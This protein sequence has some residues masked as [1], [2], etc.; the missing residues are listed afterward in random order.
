MHLSPSGLGIWQ[1]KWELEDLSFKYLDPDAYHQ[2]ARQLEGHRQEREAFVR[3]AMAELSTGSRRSRHRGGAVGS[4]QAHL[5][6]PQE[7]ATQGCRV[8]RDL[9]PPRAQVLVDDVRACYGA[10]GVV[11]SMWRPIP[12]Q[13][14]D[15]IAVPKNNMYQSLH[16]AVVALD[17]KPLEV[18]IRS[19]DMHRVSEIGVAAHWRYKE[20]TRS[21]RAYDAKLAWVR[22]LIEWQQDVSDATEFI[23]GVKLDIFQDQVFVFTPAGD[24]KDMPAGATPLDF[25][26]RVHT[27]VGHACIGTKVNN[28]LVRSTTSCATATS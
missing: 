27:E 3:R 12:G 28:R 11:H 14:D 24:V 2:L 22:Q 20:G 16:T 13:F 1:I 10:L 21:D 7:D 18:Q 8:R 9:R 19:H 4:S 15:Y 17:G 6:H 5:Q 26:Y 25:A 23:E